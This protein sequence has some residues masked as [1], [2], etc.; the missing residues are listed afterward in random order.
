MIGSSVK[1]NL[2]V[3]LRDPATLLAV[4][5][6]VI[7]EFMC[8][9]NMGY[10]DLYGNE[11]GKEF[12]LTEGAYERI[13]NTMVNLVANPIANI[14][15]VFMGVVLAVNVFK[16]IRTQTYDVMTASG[17]GFGKY[18]LAK[19]IS[20]YILALGLSFGL[21]MLH[22][23]LFVIFCLPA[24]P[25]F[26]VA[27][28]LIANFVMMVALYT[29]ELSLSFLFAL[30]WISLTGVPVVGV[31]FNAVY[32]Y[33][34]SMFGLS[35]TVYTWYLHVTP[36]VMYWYF[37]YWIT[38]PPEQ[39]FSARLLCGNSVTNFLWADIYQVGISCGALIL[40]SVI[41]AV[42]SYFLLKRRFQKS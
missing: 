12:Y 8:G 32:A 4:L 10:Q 20:Y 33:I 22:E 39:W 42:L 7:M 26:D 24:N 6:A 3:I 9:I 2:K 18:Y 38:Y 5:A 23:I 35:L 36:E 37:K 21:T 19:I 1:N 41:L 40:L 15:F 25:N 11:L 16:D 17:M 30:F 14:V 31:L 13:L 28:V 34:P 27:K 29:S